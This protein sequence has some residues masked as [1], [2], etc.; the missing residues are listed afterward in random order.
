M[1]QNKEI[2][3]AKVIKPGRRK[4]R[5]KTTTTEHQIFYPHGHMLEELTAL[6][7]G[8]FPAITDDMIEKKQD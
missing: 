8:T 5:S 3:P 4:G 6:E 7:T 1:A 2:Q